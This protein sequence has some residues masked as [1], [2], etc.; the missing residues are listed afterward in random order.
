MKIDGNQI[1][2]GNILKIHSKLWKVLKTQH[3]QPGKGG[4][5]LQAEMK[6]IINGT[7]MN[8][9][10]RSS[11]TVERAILD[12]KVCQYL[13]KDNTKYIFMD[14]NTYEQIEIGD[15]IVSELQSKFLKENENI[16]IQ[17][18]ENQIVGINIA[19]TVKL[20]IIETEA[21]VKGQTATS[22]FKPATLEGDIK[23]TIPPFL[24]VGDTVIINTNDFSY[25]EKVKK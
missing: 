10:F 23:T 24:K 14:N 22:S 15:D 4:A 12:E 20:K 1:K 25:L 13:Y 19:D 9:R 5:Y 3:T 17:F 7:K 11:E 2:V 16:T 8:E 21:V 18:Y 6:D